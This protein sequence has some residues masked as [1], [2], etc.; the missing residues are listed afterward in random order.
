MQATELKNQTQGKQASGPWKDLESGLVAWTDFSA[1]DRERIVRHFAPKIKYLS[2]RLKARLPKN[3]EL[4][5][6]IS[7]GT[8]GLMECLGKFQPQL[9]IKF[10]TYAETRIRGA[11]L[12]DLR[13]LDWFPRSLRQKV[14][15]VEEAATRIEGEKGRTATDKEISEQ[16]NFTEKEV[17]EAQEAMQHQL[18]LSLDNFQEGS[19][20]S[21]DNLGDNEPYKKAVTSELIDKMT[22]LIEHL[23]PREKLVLSLYYTE[24]LNMREVAEVMGV[25][26]GRVSQLHTQALTRLRREFRSQVGES[27][28]F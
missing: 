12:D 4:S 24:E 14:R 7:A 2:L 8:L 5:E 23:T 1:I 17:R 22:S 11:M 20:F 16:T 25:T 26:E 13:R 18:C 28:S 3:I 21:T 19:A 15:Q 27:V 10:D 6:L 9:G